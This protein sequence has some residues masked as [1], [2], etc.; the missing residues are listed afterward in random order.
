MCN[1]VLAI[2]AASVAVSAYGAIQQ[3]RA[4]Q[5]ASESDAQQ[6]EIYAAEARDEAQ[7]EAADIRKGGRIVASASRAA[8]AG[9]GVRLDVG[10]T[11]DVVEKQIVEDSEED[12][13]MSILTGERRARSA[14][15]QAELSRSSARNASRSAFLS[16]SG[17]ALGA[18]LAYN[19]WANAR[20]R[21]EIDSGRV[22]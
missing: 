20:Q 21:A 10:G 9:S 19:R 12:A 6:A 17:T 22:Y 3:G 5:Q 18:G 14:R 4:V 11:P 1:P 16:A 15:Q 13:A 7:Q 8:F 2:G